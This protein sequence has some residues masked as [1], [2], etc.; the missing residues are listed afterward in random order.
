MMN[1][2]FESII[3]ICGHFGACI[4]EN[5]EALVYRNKYSHISANRTLAKLEAD[6]LLKRMDRGKY[7]T[8]AYKLTPKGVKLFVNMY[9]YEPKQYSSSDKLMHSIQILNLYTHLIR[10]SVNK[11]LIKDDYNIIEERYKL[12]FVVQKT[13]KF[14]KEG[15][16]KEIIPDALV[17]YKFEE[18]KSRIFF[19][20]IENSN[21]KTPWVANKTLG[22]Y[23]S[24]YIT[25][26]WK[27]AQWNTG[28]EVKLYPPVVVIAY[29]EFKAKELQREFNKKKKTDF[30]KYYFTDYMS[31]K[32]NNFSDK[33]FYNINGEKCS[34]L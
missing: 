22:N 1:P 27:S 31:L 26:A 32:N 19:V 23:E 11:G 9:G 28:K 25:G 2:N 16:E 4:R 13:I 33:I 29:S 15:K 20:E 30:I 3:F 17:K 18:N 24:F 5:I 34:F 7:K 6:G 21:R 10:D 14:I 12:P 8:N